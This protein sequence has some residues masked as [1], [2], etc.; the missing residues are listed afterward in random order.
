MVLDQGLKWRQMTVN[1]VD[2]EMLATRRFETEEICRLFQVPPPLIQDYSH[3]T[4]TNSEQA[5]RWF[6][7]FCLLPWVRKV[8]AEFS[9]SLFAGTP[10]ALEL[11]MSGFDRGDAA[12]RW[13]AH[14]IAVESGIL[15]PDEVREVEGWNPRPKGAEGGGAA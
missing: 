5:G 15:T 13:A 6:A 11:D 2:A 14:K 1:P 10:Y 4:F 7:Q 12:N 3:N 8:E 9:R